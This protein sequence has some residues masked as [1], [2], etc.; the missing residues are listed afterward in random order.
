MSAA[1]FAVSLAVAQVPSAP[2]KCSWSPPTFPHH[3]FD[4]GPLAAQK[5]IAF[6]S[7]NEMENLLAGTPFAELLGSHVGATGPQQ[8]I[9]ISVCG[10]TR[11]DGDSLCRGER[12]PGVLTEKSPE[13]PLTRDP[14]FAGLGGVLGDVLG[15]GRAP[16]RPA[17]CMILGRRMAGPKFALIDPEDATRGLQIL[18]DKGDECSAGS[19]AADG[20]VRPGRRSSILFLLRCSLDLRAQGVNQHLQAE[21]QRRDGCQW[22]VSITTA[23]A[24][25][26]NA[27][28][29]TTCAPNCPRTWL[30]DGECDPGCSVRACGWDGGDCERGAVRPPPAHAEAAN[31]CAPGCERAWRGDHECDEE[32]N[33]EACQWDGGDCSGVCAPGCADR[34]LGD[35][36]CDDECNTGTCEWDRGDCLR[37]GRP[38]ARAR[39]AW[40]C[41]SAWLGDGQCDMGCNVTSCGFDHADCVAGWRHTSTSTARDPE[42]SDSLRRPTAATLIAHA[43]MPLL[44][45]K[46]QLHADV[47][48]LN[49]PVLLGTFGA[50]VALIFCGCGAACCALVAYCCL[51]SRAQPR[52]A[53][54]AVA[55]NSA[56]W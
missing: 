56:P 3:M 12:A 13:H 38:V 27:G 24:C 2:K 37:N 34:W 32:C 49:V 44:G 33:N 9:V 42:G 46:V 20:T 50:T 8:T 4:L 25:P 29:E 15:G 48:Q 45:A 39:C 14:A 51:R 16:P 22:V 21:V 43:D 19:R 30:G 6:K 35:G 54:T 10:D 17:R 40:G 7:G 28:P 36:E 31:A 5:D 47:S 52:Y 55:M 53:Y 41:P 26:V 23:A 18:Y 1:A 11:G